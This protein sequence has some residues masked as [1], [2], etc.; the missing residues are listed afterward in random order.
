MNLA[1]NILDIGKLEEG[2]L[3]V[4]PAEMSAGQIVSLA[5]KYHSNVLFG[6]KNISVTIVE[7]IDGFSVAVDPYLM[8][9]LVQNLFSNAAKYTDAGGRVDLSFASTGDEN[10]VTFFSS[11]P[12]I[13]SDQ[14]ELIFEKY[15]QIG[16]TTSPYSKGLG[17]FFCKMVM[18][19]HGGRIWLDTDERGNCFRLGFKA[20]VSG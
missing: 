18:T 7:P 10:I 6:E 19:A 5:R 8:D 4:Q 16:R 14:K 11:A 13:P 9:R 17:L 3:K 20:Q 15:S 12:V 2:K 1:M